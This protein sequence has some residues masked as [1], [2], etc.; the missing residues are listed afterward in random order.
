MDGSYR[1]KPECRLYGLWY[2]EDE[3]LS[4]G[5]YHIAVHHTVSVSTADIVLQNSILHTV[6]PHFLWFISQL[7]I[8][9]SVIPKRPLHKFTVNS[10]IELN[11]QWTSWI[12]KHRCSFQTRVCSDLS[13]THHVSKTNRGCTPSAEELACYRILLQAGAEK[14][15]P[16]P[17]W[18]CASSYHQSVCLCS[19]DNTRCVFT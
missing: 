5:P 18:S 12:R 3:D 8:P 1:G 19:N 16:F 7:M 11:R 10:L 9:K 4:S 17:S 13:V 2:S 6:E 14:W 15:I